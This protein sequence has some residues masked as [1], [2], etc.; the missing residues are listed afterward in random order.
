MYSALTSNALDNEC[1]IC[2]TV[3]SNSKFEF[4]WKFKF[5]LLP[6]RVLCPLNLSSSPSLWSLPLSLSL[7]LTLTVFSPPSPSRSKLKVSNLTFMSFIWIYGCSRDI[8]FPT[9]LRFGTS[10]SQKSIRIILKLD[11]TIVLINAINITRVSVAEATRACRIRPDSGA[12]SKI[13][14]LTDSR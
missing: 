2:F 13:V 10:S 6:S 5:K 8:I 1:Y 7:T 4:N 14:D 3:V 12:S 9:A 11:V